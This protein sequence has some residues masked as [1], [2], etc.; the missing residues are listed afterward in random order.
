MT[1]FSLSSPVLPCPPPSPAC[2]ACPSLPSRGVLLLPVWEYD[3]FP[4]P[5]PA[6]PQLP[7]LP[8]LLLAWSCQWPSQQP[9]PDEGAFLLGNCFVL[10]SVPNCLSISSLSSTWASFLIDACQIRMWSNIILILTFMTEFANTLILKA[11]FLKFWE[12][13]ILL[14]LRW[15]LYS[16][17]WN[18]TM[19]TFQRE[20]FLS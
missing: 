1:S 3:G 10:W 16:V 2:S 8:E 6:V 18:V 5:M 19:F 20:K 15:S 7:A 9:T 12:T 17:Q 11:E 13:K 4:V 14:H